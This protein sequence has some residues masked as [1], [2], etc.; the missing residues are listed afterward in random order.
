[1]LTSPEV[2]SL[3][4]GKFS[5][6]GDRR[7]LRKNYFFIGLLEGSVCNCRIMLIGSIWGLAA[8]KNRTVTSMHSPRFEPA[9]VTSTTAS[10][11]LAIMY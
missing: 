11:L 5:A 8:W 3:S 4:S 9:G 7:L 6:F 10:L 2:I 1:M